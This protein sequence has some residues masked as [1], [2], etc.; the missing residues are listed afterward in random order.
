MKSTQNQTNPKDYNWRRIF[1]S[2]EGLILAIGILSALLGL[3]LIGVLAIWSPELSGIIGS[4]VFSNLMLG[5]SV[6]LLIGY[7]AGQGHLLV[8]GVNLLTETILVLLFFPLFV[9]S[10]N[11][12]PLF[13]KLQ[14]LIERIHRQAEKHQDWVRRYGV[15]G[16]FLLVFFPFWMTGPVIGCALGC[17]IGLRP[18]HNLVTV[19]SGTFLAMLAWAWLL[20]GLHTQATLF[21]SWGLLLLFG[22]LLGI[23]VAGYWFNI[24][25]ARVSEPD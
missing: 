7:A 8:I 23:A 1:G 24:R 4:M 10:L 11:K 2:F 6:S 18:L 25:Q 20:Y 12:L 5:R 16:I 17:L 15:I 9:F 21:G 19:L 13:P 22:V 3:G 14:T